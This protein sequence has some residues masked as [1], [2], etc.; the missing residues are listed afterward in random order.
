MPD[1]HT[2]DYCGPDAGTCEEE[3]RQGIIQHRCAECGAELYQEHFDPEG[4][5]VN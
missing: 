3:L 4:Q 2:C 1:M 5:D